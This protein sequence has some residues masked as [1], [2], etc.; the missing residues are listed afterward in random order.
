VHVQA[1]AH[2][3]SDSYAKCWNLLLLL[4]MLL[5]LPCTFVVLA[6]Q[7]PA[8]DGVNGYDSV[9]GGYHGK[10]QLTLI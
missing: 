5:L 8:Q 4:L 3:R 7:G 10:G 2:H 6:V 1:R 9:I